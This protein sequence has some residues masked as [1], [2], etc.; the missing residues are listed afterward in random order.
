MVVNL[1]REHPTYGSDMYNL[2]REHCPGWRRSW[3]L[4]HVMLPLTQNHQPW[5]TAEVRTQV[6]GPNVKQ[7]K[8]TSTFYISVLTLHSP[9]Q[10]TWHSGTFLGYSVGSHFSK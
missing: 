3:F 1:W 4:A 9:T 5:V 2:V 8:F 10:G 6:L 7:V